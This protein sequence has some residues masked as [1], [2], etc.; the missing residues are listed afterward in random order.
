MTGATSNSPVVISGFSIC[1]C[2]DHSILRLPIVCKQSPSRQC[3]L[4]PLLRDRRPRSRTWASQV[5]G[6][7][8]KHKSSFP[9]NLTQSVADAA[10]LSLHPS[11][12][13][14][15]CLKYSILEVYKLYP[16][17]ISQKTPKRSNIKISTSSK[18]HLIFTK[19][20]FWWW[21]CL[22]KERA[23]YF[24]DTYFYI[25]FWKEMNLTS[26]YNWNALLC[27]LNSHEQ[28]KIKATEKSHY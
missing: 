24:W 26:N 12:V 22:H 9:P 27:A 16:V 13:F 5:P 21:L 20:T 1:M 3:N 7:S 4:F 14:N 23:H 18:L 19:V 10:F 17:C 11:N 2:S 25:N 6:F 28:K 15:R 8:P